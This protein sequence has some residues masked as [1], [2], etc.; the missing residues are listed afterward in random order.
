LTKNEFNKQQE[1]LDNEMSKIWEKPFLDGITK[2][3][4]YQK[5]PIKILWILK[6]PNGM[7]GGNHRIFHQDIRDY[8][9]WKSTYGNIMRVSYGIL[10]GIRSYKEIP[11]INTKECEIADA[12]VLDEIAI[13]NI[14]KS[15]GRSTTPLGKMEKEYNRVGVKDFLFKQIEFINPDIII[16]THGV[17]QFFIDQVGNNEIKK[18]NAE[19][20]ARNKNRLIIWTT[21]PNRAPIESYCNN[22]LN[23]II[24]D[25]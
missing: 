11:P 17:K 8:N 12:I 6:E 7:G 3:E 9:R 21:H 13:I 1:I 5:T 22:I 19:E 16:N 4:L 15:G 25:F 2:Y 14:N 18:I 10:E 23:I 24:C 20:Y